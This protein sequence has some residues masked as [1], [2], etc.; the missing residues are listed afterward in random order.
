M[1]TASLN[2]LKQEL[3]TLPPKELL[4]LCL[5]LA[6]FKKE[7]KELLSYL[8]FESADE[9]SYI[10]S[11]KLFITEEFL[12]VN[13]SI[14]YQAKKSI[15]KI[16]RITNKYIRYSGSAIVEVELLI[17]FCTTARDSGIKINKSTALVNLYNNQVKKINKAIISLHEDLQFDYQKQL[18]NL[19]ILKKNFFH[20]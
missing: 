15:R 11:I 16:L 10:E 17:H 20:F 13:K 8:L 7:N 6:R 2:E 5:R 4:E 19:E 12:T 9:Q 1:K 3:I 18:D 14:L